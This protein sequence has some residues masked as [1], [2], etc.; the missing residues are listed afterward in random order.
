LCLLNSCTC[1]SREPY[2]ASEQDVLLYTFRTMLAA[3]TADGGRKR[4]R[5]E[6]PPWW[7]DGSHERAMFSHLAKWKRGDLRDPDSG[8]HPLTHLAWRALAVAYQET[9]GQVDPQGTV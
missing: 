2:D 6:K 8:S 4:A 3:V 9:Y 7:Q 5:G 1:P